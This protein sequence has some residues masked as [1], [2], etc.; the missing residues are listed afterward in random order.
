MELSN[1][2]Q[3]RVQMSTAPNGKMTYID[4]PPARFVFRGQPDIE[5]LKNNP[6]KVKDTHPLAM[7]AIPR[8]L[9][10][11]RKPTSLQREPQKRPIAKTT[12]SLVLG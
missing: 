12:F 8:Q 4:T 6:R 9:D 7:M 2:T 3:A 1:F 5:S 11:G 10:V